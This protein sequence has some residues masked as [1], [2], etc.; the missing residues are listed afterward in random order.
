MY[1]VFLLYIHGRFLSLSSKYFYIKYSGIKPEF[2]TCLLEYKMA[3]SLEES[4]GYFKTAAFILLVAAVLQ[5][6]GFATPNWMV[7]SFRDI[8]GSRTGL[9][10]SCAEF[11]VVACEETQFQGE[12]Q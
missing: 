6:V 4:T 10:Q 5:A 8:I 7:L 3:K 11:L 12:G 9:W 1:L 2:A